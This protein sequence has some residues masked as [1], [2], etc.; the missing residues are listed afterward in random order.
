MTIKDQTKTHPD[1][2]MSLNKGQAWDHVVH[3]K[4]TQLS[5]KSGLNR[6]GTKGKQAFTN[7][8]LQLHMQDPFQP[9]NPKTLSKNEY[10][11]VLESYLFLK[12]K[13]YQSIKER[14]VACGNKQRGYIIKKDATSLTAALE[15]VLLTSTIHAK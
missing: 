12:Q 5:K 6:W 1:T 4:M 13:R 3:Y 7:N 2:H 8:L 15:S 9:I 10:D 11:K 14:M